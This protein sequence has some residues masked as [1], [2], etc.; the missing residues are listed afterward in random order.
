MSNVGWVGASAGWPAP[1]GKILWAGRAGADLG[2]RRGDDGVTHH[3]SSTSLAGA[4]E[5]HPAGLPASG[6]F[7]SPQR[8]KDVGP[9]EPIGRKPQSAAAKQGVLTFDRRGIDAGHLDGYC[10]SGGHARAE[11]ARFAN[12]WLVAQFPQKIRTMPRASVSTT[13]L[14]LPQ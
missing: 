2:Q 7:V 8:V 14:P 11:A 10:A 3:M 5:Q 13:I 12:G 4:F 6:L 9:G 1:G